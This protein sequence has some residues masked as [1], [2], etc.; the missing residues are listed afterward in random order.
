MGG[1]QLRAGWRMSRA[2]AHTTTQIMSAGLANASCSDLARVVVDGRLHGRDDL[3]EV[4]EIV[5]GPQIVHWWQGILSRG[6]KRSRSSTSLDGLRPWCGKERK[7][8]LLDC[9]Q[10]MLD[11]LVRSWIKGPVLV[12]WEEIANGLQTLFQVFQRGL[13]AHVSSVV[14]IRD[15]AI[16]CTLWLVGRIVPRGAIAVVAL[17]RVVHG[18]TGV[19]LLSMFGGEEACRCR[20]EGL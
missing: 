11:L 16:G 1:W 6:L 8:I 7:L 14:G 13:C 18:H 9:R 20:S 17:L 2:G 10:T 19:Q 3:V 5:F 4:Q 12:F 15:I